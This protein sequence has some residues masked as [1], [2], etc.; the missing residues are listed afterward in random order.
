MLIHDIYIYTYIYLLSVL[1]HVQHIIVCMC[2]Y[3]SSPAHLYMVTVQVKEKIERKS[4]SAPDTRAG[5]EPMARGVFS[6]I[7]PTTNTTDAFSGAQ[8]GP[9]PPLRGTQHCHQ[10]STGAGNAPSCVDIPRFTLLGAA[11]PETVNTAQQTTVGL[12]GEERSVSDSKLFQVRS[13]VGVVS[14]R[15]QSLENA[16]VG[17]VA[18]K[19][20]T[21][22]NPSASLLNKLSKDAERILV[23][24]GTL[25]ALS[26][27]LLVFVRLRD[28]LA[29]NHLTN[30]PLP[31]RFICILIGPPEGD[32]DYHEAGRVLA[33]VLSNEVRMQEWV[34]AW[35]EGAEE[36]E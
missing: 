31:T 36:C 11:G 29:M 34:D 12:Q 4:S 6:A 22:R 21:R 5:N 15:K 33:T 3:P 20:T 10:L 13:S 35:W 25:E 30:P 8:I 32:I 27:P 19:V 28:T 1:I 18:P 7:S 17:M 9:G 2:N 14:T 26:A 23:M 24:V 16:D